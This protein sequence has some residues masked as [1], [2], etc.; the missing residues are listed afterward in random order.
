MYTMPYLYIHLDVTLRLLPYLGL[1]YSV[2]YG[3][4]I[5]LFGVNVF[6]FFWLYTQEWSCWVTCY[7]F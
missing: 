1:L 3:G 5:C 6:G 4:C 2:G 7:C